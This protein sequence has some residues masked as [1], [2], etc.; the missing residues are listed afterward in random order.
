VYGQGCGTNIY[1]ALAGLGE[2]GG[3]NP[4]RCPGLLYFGLSG[5]PCLS[6][7]IKYDILLA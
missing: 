2:R 4:G 3:I 5:L 1:S 7:G 6:P